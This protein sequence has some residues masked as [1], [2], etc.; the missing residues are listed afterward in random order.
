LCT[1]FAFLYSPFFYA[2]VPFVAPGAHF[3][4]K[5]ID[6]LQALY[7]VAANT[8][9]QRQRRRP[10]IFETLDI[11][12]NAINANKEAYALHYN[13]VL[14]WQCTE[15]KDADKY[16]AENRNACWAIQDT[17]SRCFPKYKDYIE[18]A[19]VRIEMNLDKKEV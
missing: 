1:I 12:N 6:K 5:P 10:M 18:S 15:H 16:Q 4:A 8:Y 7:K 13:E 14:C 19:F 3:T 2:F 17:L 9:K 11:V